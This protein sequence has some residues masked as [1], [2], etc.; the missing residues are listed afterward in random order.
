MPSEKPR[1]STYTDQE[2]IDK[3]KIVSALHGT[4]MSKY[5]EEI[6]KREIS[7]YPIE[8]DPEGNTT[9]RKTYLL[10]NVLFFLPYYNNKRNIIA[11]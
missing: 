9:F 1:I 7:Y 6:I 4:T 3:F 5:L 8:I 2:T 10:H 11:S